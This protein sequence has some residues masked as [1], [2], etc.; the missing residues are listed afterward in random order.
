MIN[1]RR[2]RGTVGHVRLF[3]GIFMD[4]RLENSEKNE[5]QLRGRFKR[6][7]KVTYKP[8]RVSAVF[9]FSVLTNVTLSIH[10]YRS[11]Y[12]LHVV[13]NSFEKRTQQH[14]LSTG[15]ENVYHA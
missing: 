7:S 8:S 1:D 15:L 11:N 14:S 5:N 6:I 4:K 3:D 9:I 13:R 12:D 10:T 2:T